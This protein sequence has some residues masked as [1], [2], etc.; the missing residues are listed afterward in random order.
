MAW[1]NPTA[2]K[3]WVFN[4]N[5]EKNKH[6]QTNEE[7]QVV[8][9]K[10]ENS[11]I[12]NENLNNCLSDKMTLETYNLTHDNQNGYQLKFDDTNWD[13]NLNGLKPLVRF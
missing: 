8:S 4:D 1:P 9:P 2:E 12:N 10:S 7:S 11:E 3:L 13:R 5:L 6:N